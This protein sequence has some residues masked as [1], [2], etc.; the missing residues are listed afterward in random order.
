MPEYALWTLV[1]SLSVYAFAVTL[2]SA[3]LSQ[4]LKFIEKEN[5]R[6][7]KQIDMIEKDKNKTISALSE[8]HNAEINEIVNRYETQI[9]QNFENT[10]KILQ[11]YHRLVSP[12]KLVFLEQWDIRH[13]NKT[14]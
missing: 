13:K 11:K 8:F 10:N 9:K 7:I 1:V 12:A 14:P 6:F 2:K 5:D 3:F 4:S